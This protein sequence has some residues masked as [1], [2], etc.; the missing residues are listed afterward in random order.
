MVMGSIP[1]PHQEEIEELETWEIFRLVIDSGESDEVAK[2]LR[3][4][5]ISCEGAHV[6]SWM[7]D[8]DVDA[9]SSV[10]PNGRRNPL[11]EFIE[12]LAAVGARKAGAATTLA[13]KVVFV[14]A[15]IEADHDREALLKDLEAI[16]EGRKA[17]KEFLKK[18]EHIGDG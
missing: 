8:P 16:R 12:V 17:A 14:A 5:G 2:I 9:N 3:R 18:T 13:K 4:R 15:K 11:D 7:N 6:R 1:T 10:T